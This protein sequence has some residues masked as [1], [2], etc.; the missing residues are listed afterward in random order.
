MAKQHKL[1]NV[2]PFYIDE[3]KPF[4]KPTDSNAPIAGLTKLKFRN[5][6]IYYALTW[7]ALALLLAGL[8]GYATYLERKRKSV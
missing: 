3:D 4:I 1:Q 2:A 5:T 8:T 6:H 7:Y